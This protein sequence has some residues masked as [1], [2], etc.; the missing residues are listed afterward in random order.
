MERFPYSPTQHAFGSHIDEINQTRDTLLAERITA[1]I[2]EDA[3]LRER[4]TRDA[5]ADAELV[6]QRKALALAHAGEVGAYWAALAETTLA[7]SVPGMPPGITVAAAAT[8]TAVA[9]AKGG[10]KG[11]SGDAAHS[12]HVRPASSRAHPRSDCWCCRTRAGAGTSAASL[13]LPR[14][15]HQR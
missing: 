1:D 10:K 8:T 7:S 2:D 3:A 6:K 15:H 5:T 14:P 13:G 11:E 12:P 4:C 9:G